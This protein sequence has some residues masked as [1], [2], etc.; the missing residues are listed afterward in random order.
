MRTTKTDWMRAVKLAAL[1]NCDPRTAAKWMH[2]RSVANVSR[3]ALE[4]AAQ[5]LGV[6]PAN[7]E[8]RASVG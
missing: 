6:A 7:P 4:R 8:P 1:A 3:A 2:G 5:A